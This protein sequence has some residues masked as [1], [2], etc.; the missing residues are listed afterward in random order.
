MYQAYVFMLLKHES[1]TC[2]KREK[3]KSLTEKYFFDLTEVQIDND[4]IHIQ[5]PFRNYDH[6]VYNITI[7]T[8][9]LLPEDY[10]K[11]QMVV[12]P[13]TMFS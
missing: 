6:V 5:Q 2:G 7:I 1:A 8:K 4:C 10:R 11:L 13:R 12:S 3:L 9:G